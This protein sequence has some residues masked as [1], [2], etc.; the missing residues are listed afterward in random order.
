MGN[1]TTTSNAPLFVENDEMPR[2]LKAAFIGLNGSG[3]TLTMA[4][5]AIGISKTYYNG[6]PV[7][8]HDS[9]SPASD[10]LVPIFKLEGVKFLRRKSESFKD[11][12]A[13]I[14]EGERNGACVYIEDSMTK[15]WAELLEGFK[16]SFRPPLEEI[17]MWHWQRIKPTWHEE[18]VRPMLASPLHVLVGGRLG[19]KWEEVTKADGKDRIEVVDSKMK[20]EGEFGHEPSILVE[21]HSDRSSSTQ[22]TETR[23]NGKRTKRG[24]R[25]GQTIHTAFIKKDR[26]RIIQG[27][28]FEWPA[29]NAYKVGD[30][31]KV[32]ASFEPHLRIYDFKGKTAAVPVASA[33]V[34]S[35]LFDHEGRGRYHQWKLQKQIALEEIEGCLTAIWPGSDAKSKKYKAMALNTLFETR[36]WAAV[37]N[38]P[39]GQLEI[40]LGRLQRIERTTKMT[41]MDTDET[42]ESVLKE[43]MEFKTD[44]ERNAAN[45]SKLEQVM[46][47]LDANQ[48]VVYNCLLPDKDIQLNDL[49]E[50]SGLTPGTVMTALSDLELRGLAGQIPGKRFVS[51]P[52]NR[53]T[54]EVAEQSAA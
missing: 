32:F 42:A 31:K 46:A 45:D 28:T 40:G 25:A 47:S 10:F 37:E 33:T 27:A 17:E 36:S 51:V 52:L 4:L 54:L 39:V 48:K 9:E 50:L 20:A 19:D 7:M 29:I 16:K 38:M 13:G 35:D 30:W 24:R 3:K 21:M 41:P 22:L 15:D 8:M 14:A 26:A 2:A 23:E 34:T 5:L 11:T 49:I 44:A 53:V 6:A 43:S 1:P 12:C 18:W